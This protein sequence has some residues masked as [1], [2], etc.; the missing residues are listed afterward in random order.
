MRPRAFRPQVA[1]PSTLTGATVVWARSSQRTDER[2]PAVITNDSV[3]S[4]LDGHR[5]AVIGASDRK[6]SFART[7]DQALVEHGY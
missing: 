5:I 6:D 4:F 1:G 2:S 3:R 7:I